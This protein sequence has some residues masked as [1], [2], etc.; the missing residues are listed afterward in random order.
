M[1]V[2]TTK[3]IREAIIGPD[4]SGQPKTLVSM[5]SNLF[6]DPTTEP[7]LLMEVSSM[8]SIINIVTIGSYTYVELRFSSETDSDLA[9]AYR[10]LEHNFEEAGKATEEQ[11]CMVTLTLLP[12][13]LE[14]RYFMAAIDPVFWAL[15]PDRAGGQFNVLRIVFESTDVRYMESDIDEEEFRTQI[16]MT[17]NN[18]NDSDEV[19]IYH[20][21][22]SEKR[23]QLDEELLMRNSEF[24][25]DKYRNDLLDYNAE[26]DEDDAIEDDDYED[27][28]E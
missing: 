23:R 17:L 22:R 21:S 19:D 5:S 13:E 6:D 24:T 15:E 12:L 3:E 28:D 9:L 16:E 14:G 18:E 25:D 26:D 8:S 4:P 2:I 10:C 20:A 11:T 1:A 27:D 7:A